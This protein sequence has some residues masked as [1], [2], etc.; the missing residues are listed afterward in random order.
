MRSMSVA[1]LAQTPLLMLPGLSYETSPAR[2]MT[3]PSPLVSV[4]LP[5]GAL[6]LPM[7]NIRNVVSSRTSRNRASK[8][9]AVAST[10]D[11]SGNVAR[12]PA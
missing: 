9:L 7:E 11:S 6:P 8:T 4:P 5:V 10:S 1:P 2:P 12:E 3:S